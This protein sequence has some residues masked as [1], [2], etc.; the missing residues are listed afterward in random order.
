MAIA[1]IVN[2]GPV[3]TL[4][5]PEDVHISSDEVEVVRR[6]DEVI[7]RERPRTL[8]QAVELFYALPEMDR[9]ETLPI[10]K[11]DDF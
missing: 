1:R 8:A 9:P 4:R 3:Q 5:L 11:R 2:D 6:G 7:L 10:E